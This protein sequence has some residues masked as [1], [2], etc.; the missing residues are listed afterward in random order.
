MVLGI[1][2]RRFKLFNRSL[3]EEPA[4]GHRVL[5]IRRGLPD[6]NLLPLNEAQ[7]H[8]FLQRLPNLHSFSSESMCDVPSS[9]PSLLSGSLPLRC[10]LQV[11]SLHE[12]LPTAINLFELLSFPTLRRL[13][14]ENIEKFEIPKGILSPLECSDTN[15]QLRVLE[16]GSYIG[17]SAWKQFSF[18][19]RALSKSL[20]Q[21]FSKKR[22][23]RLYAF[24]KTF[25]ATDIFTRT[26][27]ASSCPISK[28]FD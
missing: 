25:H 6:T 22:V 12:S 24:V 9:V 5:F 28:H 17:P 27:L 18:R 15:S 11:L 7:L 20:L 8:F 14:V 16:L 26:D 3:N 1:P 23:D 21:R 19:F 4:Y 10:T 2:S 13:R